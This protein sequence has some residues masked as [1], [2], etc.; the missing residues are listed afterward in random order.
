MKGAEEGGPVLVVEGDNNRGSGE[1]GVVLL[2]PAAL[3]ADVRDGPAQ[4]D[5]L[6]RHQHSN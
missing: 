2:G 5:S 6:R 1:G 3:V 4:Q